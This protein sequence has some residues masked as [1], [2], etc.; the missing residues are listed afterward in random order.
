MYSDD[1]RKLTVKTFSD[2]KQTN[3]YRQLTQVIVKTGFILFNIIIEKVRSIIEKV[4][5]KR[6]EEAL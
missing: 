3:K 5:Q 2:R 4:L 1:S 6:R